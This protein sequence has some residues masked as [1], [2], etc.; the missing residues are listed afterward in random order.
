MVQREKVYA[1]TG[2]GGHLGKAL[3]EQLQKEDCK[4]RGLLLLGEKHD[5]YPNVTWYYGDVT[6]KES[7]FHFF[8]NLKDTNLYVIHAAGRIDISSKKM[9]DKLYQ[10]NVCGTENVIELAEEAHALRIVHVASVDAF[11]ALS[12]NIDETAALCDINNYYG[13][14]ALSKALGMQY[15]K[16]RV[17]NG[18]DIITVCPSGIL[19]PYDSGNNHLVQMINDYLKGKIPGVIPGGYDIVDVRDVAF[20]IISAL[21]EAPFGATYLLSGHQSNLKMILEYAKELT[22][23]GKKV[24]VFP[25]FLARLGLPF[26]SAYCRLKHMRPLYTSF[27]LDVVHNANT[28]QHDKAEKEL[29]YHPREI[30]ETIRD[31][32]NYLG[33]KIKC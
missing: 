16:E 18:S 13:G 27:A 14:Y 21:K 15:V 4:I 32:V 22:G 1:I 19:G 24:R 25:L 11:Q 10:V 29:G 33:Y 17:K 8:E 2:A 20:G 28:F 23:F 12:Q 30:K 26:V 6:K 31:T 9:T 5:E 3:I 7:L